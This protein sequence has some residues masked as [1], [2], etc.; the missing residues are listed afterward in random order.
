MDSFRQ[1]NLH[2]IDAL[3]EEQEE[4][5]KRQTDTASGYAAAQTV[6]ESV[7]KAAETFRK[8]DNY[9][10]N[11]VTYD[12]AQAKINAKKNIFRDNKSVEDP[13]TGKRIVQTKAEAEA[14]YGNNWAEHLAES[15][16]I[17]PLEK[18]YEETKGKVWN[19]TDD[20]KRAANSEDNIAVVSRKYNNPK[21]SRTNEEYVK[22]EG[23]LKEKGVRLTQEG[24]KRAI[25]DGQ[26]A[27]RSIN[28]QL[29]KAAV[30]NVVKTGHEAGKLGAKSAGGTALTMSGIMNIVSVIK[31]EKEVGE[32][33]TDTIKDGGKAAVTGY[34]TSSG[35]TVASHSLSSSSSKFIQGLAKSNIPGKV[36]TGVLVAGDTL[37]RYGR[38]EITTQE[39]MIELGEKGLTFATMSYSMSVGQILIP[40]P[41]VGAAVG[42]LV[43]SLLTSTYYSNLVNSL[44]I[45]E[46]EHQ[47]RV[48]I[49]REC[50]RAA[51]QERAFRK[52]LEEYLES[53]FKEYKDCFDGALSAMKLSYQ[54]GDADGVIASANEITYKLGGQVHYE[55]VED[56]RNF[57][58]DDSVDIL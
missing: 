49:I 54:M 19:T 50:R 5:R 21:R 32:A 14:S 2:E 41:V 40:I 53:Y 1:D 12:S 58:D 22:D 3:P 24:Q 47:E 6:K 35:L 55:S 31:G 7:E 57:F 26:T 39:C 30:E 9:T 44:K 29:K 28:R 36:I 46:L 51:E 48:R 33:V 11:R 4:K 20:I 16:H 34:V 38:G 18:I 56:F 42:A 43:G 8:P 25:Q 15:D 10:G 23:Y 45:K 17:K 52:E 13:Y 27:E 37:R